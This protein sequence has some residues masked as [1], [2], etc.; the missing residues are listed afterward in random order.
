M[1]KILLI[2]ALAMAPFVV[3]PATNAPSV[4]ITRSVTGAGSA[5]IAASAAVPLFVAGLVGL[6]F[7]RRRTK[8]KSVTFTEPFAERADAQGQSKRPSRKRNKFCA[9][10]ASHHSQAPKVLFA[11]AAC[12]DA[13]YPSSLVC[14]L[15]LLRPSLVGVSS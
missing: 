15:L 1:K 11:L 5:E 3:T 6:G 10:S 14:P 8:Q 12:P 7:L 2:M 4:E 13:A 9:Q